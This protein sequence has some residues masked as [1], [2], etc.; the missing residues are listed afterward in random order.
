MLNFLTM[1]LQKT[2]DL[3]STIRVPGFNISLISIM[4]GSIGAMVSISLLKMIFGLGNTS[5]SGGL[6]S[7]KSLS[8]RDVSGGN[9]KNIKIAKERI[10]DRF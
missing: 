4:F 9:N 7:L 5:V 2:Y 3:L 6:S 8:S 1:F 10:G